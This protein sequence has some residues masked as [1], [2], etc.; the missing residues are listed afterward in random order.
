MILLLI[1]MFL[2]PPSYAEIQKKELW[3]IVQNKRVV[4]WIDPVSMNAAMDRGDVN[5]V[6]RLIQQSL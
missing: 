5:A 1:S 2:A 4:G 3:S 6:R